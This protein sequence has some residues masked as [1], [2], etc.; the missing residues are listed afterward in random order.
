[1]CVPCAQQPDELG[2]SANQTYHGSDGTEDCGTRHAS[3]CS[4]GE[5]RMLQAL[6]GRISSQNSE[7]GEATWRFYRFP[8]LVP[9]TGHD[10]VTSCFSDTRSTN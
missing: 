6:L 4:K 9:G 10:P 8:M 7:S 2:H 3:M 5:T 1:M